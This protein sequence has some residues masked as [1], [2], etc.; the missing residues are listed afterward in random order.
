[1]SRPGAPE[2]GLHHV[3]ERMARAVA[4]SAV[5]L[6]AAGCRTVEPGGRTPT[7]TPTC[8]VLYDA[9]SSR[10]RL[11]IYEQTATGWTVHNGP[12]T[13]ALADP[14]RGNRGKT[15]DD[16]GGTVDAMIAALDDMRTDGP[17]DR[18]GVPRWQAFDWQRRC[19]IQAAY[20]Y[21]TAGMRIAERQDAAAS[22]QVYEMARDR[23]AGVLGVP[24]TAR[25]LSAFEEGLFA[26]LARSEILTDNDFG[27]AELGGGSLQVT[28]PCTGCEGART[29]RVMDRPIEIYSHSFLDWGQDEAW[30]RFGH[31]AA[32]ERGAGLANP[33]W[34][35]ADCESVI[36]GFTDVAA[37]VT[38]YIDATPA[39]HWYLSDAFFYMKSDDIENFCR[40]G[41]DSG[42]EPESS[43]FRA[44]YQQYVLKSLALPSNAEKSAANW[45][46]GAVVCSATRCL[47]KL[48]SD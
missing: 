44:V 36:R 24:V 28:F 35:P 20:V 17:P 5:V 30:K 12:G 46:L 37:T 25:T 27:V 9:G 23:L 42:Y 26:W 16:A 47:D 45:T 33:D 19:E 29:V 41:S 3:F 32:C 13:E 15:M 14:I 6:L 21:G 40:L 18:N 1:M 31:V 2:P 10:S 7:G 4:L 8:Y 11:F 39:L 48:E 38:R 22:R 43:C 34:K